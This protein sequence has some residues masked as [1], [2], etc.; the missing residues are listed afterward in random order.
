MFVFLFSF[1]FLHL[2]IENMGPI[3]KAESR[4]GRKMIDQETEKKM[5]VCFLVSLVNGGFH[6][7]NDCANFQRQNSPLFKEK[8]I[9]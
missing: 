3:H 6:G 7:G 2:V 1:S 4:R 8:K 5:T 9:Y